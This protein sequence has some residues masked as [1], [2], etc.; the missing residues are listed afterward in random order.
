MK[1]EELLNDKDARSVLNRILSL[2]PNAKGEL[3]WDTKFHLLCAVLMSAQTTDK[4]VNAVTPQLFADYPDSFALAEAS[5]SDIED[6]IKTIGLYHNKAKHLKETAEI[7]SQK[8]DGEIPASKK[9]LMKLPGVGEKTANVVLAEGFKIPAIAVDTHVS[10]ISKTFKIVPESAKPHDVEKRLEELLP[11]DKW[12]LTHHAMIL[13]GRYT[14]PA[15]SKGNPY[16][17]LPPEK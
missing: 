7:I 6:H 12:I 17:Y 5:I 16:D 11:K 15:R 3:N 8:Y 13:F 14:M 4:M 9:E 10:R 1:N 2:Y